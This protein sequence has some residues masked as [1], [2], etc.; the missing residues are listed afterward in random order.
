MI[1]LYLLGGI[2]GAQKTKA[3]VIKAGPKGRLGVLCYLGLME[4][5]GLQCL[6]A[7][8]ARYPQVQAVFLFGSRAVGRA[9][10]ESDWDLALYLEPPEPDP[11]LEI[12][13]ELVEAGLERADIV[14]LHQA[15]PVLAFEAVRT[16]RVVYRREEFDLGSYV[17]RLVRMYWDL[18]PLLKVQR[19]AIKRRWLGDPA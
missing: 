5:Q 3:L 18:E 1:V 10:P 11:T 7:V 16:N 12:L 15:P 13:S 9:R 4:E 14:L 2:R 6:R 17:S 8:C 19:E